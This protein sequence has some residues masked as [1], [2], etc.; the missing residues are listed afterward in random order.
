[1][2]NQVAKNKLK[3]LSQP[4]IGLLIREL[5]QHL[6]LTQEEFAARSGVVFSTVN[7]WEKGRAHPS[8][9]ALKQIEMMLIELGEPNVK[10]LKKYSISI[11]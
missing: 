7:R 3:H 10:I 6:K 11:K 5:R 1:M 9:M 2:T 4:H 8:P